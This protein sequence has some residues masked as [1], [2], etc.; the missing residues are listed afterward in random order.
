[1]EKK[2]N[3]YPFII[4]REERPYCPS[5]YANGYVAINESHPLW[6][7]HYNRIPISVHGGLTFSDKFDRLPLQRMEWL[8]SVPENQDKLWVLGFDTAHLGDNISRWPKEACIE[9]VMSL[10]DQVETW[11]GEI[12]EPWFNDEDYEPSEEDN[13]QLSEP[14][15]DEYNN[16]EGDEGLTEEDVMGPIGD[17]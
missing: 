12:Q 7:V 8:E 4:K 9:E 16:P 15:Y 6:G 13:E 2:Y 17:K 11:D 3:V 1:M 10:K 14:W 5:G